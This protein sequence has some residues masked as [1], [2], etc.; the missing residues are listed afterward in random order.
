MLALGSVWLQKEMAG[1]L[2]SS[3][4]QSLLQRNPSLE[5]QS[6]QKKQLMMVMIFFLPS[7]HNENHE[8]GVKYNGA[9]NIDDNYVRESGNVSATEQ[10]EAES[11]NKMN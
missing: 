10:T 7:E 2:K 3:Q 5:Y 11:Q 6:W 4:S 9:V 8:C 1:Q